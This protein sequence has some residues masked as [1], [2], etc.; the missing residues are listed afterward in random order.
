MDASTQWLHSLDSVYHV[1]LR[2]NLN[3]GALTHHCALYVQVGWLSL[4]V[5]RFLP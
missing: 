3:S 4:T 2:F 1:A 5:W